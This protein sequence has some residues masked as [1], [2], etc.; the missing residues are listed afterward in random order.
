MK[1]NFVF[2]LIAHRLTRIEL[3][4][5]QSGVFKAGFDIIS[6]KDSKIPSFLREKY[7]ML[8]G[9]LMGRL[10]VDISLLDYNYTRLNK[11]LRL[12]VY[13]QMRI[14]NLRNEDVPIIDE[15]E[16]NCFLCDNKNK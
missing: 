11:Y 6:D 16:Y 10:K 13:E 1:L 15:K 4:R 8:Y 14:F 12:L 2:N 3:V 5:R 7:E 9:D